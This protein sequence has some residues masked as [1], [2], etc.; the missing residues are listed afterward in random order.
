MAK[1]AASMLEGSENAFRKIYTFYKRRDLPPDFRNVTDFC[2]GAA[3]E[4]VRDTKE[5]LTK[6]IIN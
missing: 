4:K 5:A 1:M 3:G 2:S 6:S